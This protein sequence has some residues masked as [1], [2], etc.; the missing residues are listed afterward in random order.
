MFWARLREKEEKEHQ[1]KTDKERRKKKLERLKVTAD[2]VLEE[3]TNFAAFEAGADFELERRNLQQSMGVSSFLT[4]PD[5]SEDEEEESR[6]R[7][8]AR[9]LEPRPSMTVGTS[10]SHSQ[11]DDIQEEGD[12][13]PCARALDSIN[14]R[15]KGKQVS[16]MLALPL[17]PTTPSKAFYIDPANVVPVMYS[18]G[19]ENIG[20]AFYNFQLYGI[21]LAN[22]LSVRST[23]ENFACFLAI[24]YIWDTSTTLELPRKTTD[25]LIAN[26]RRPRINFS[27]L[28]ILLYSLETELS[29]GKIEQV[30]PQD[31]ELAVDIVDIFRAMKNDLPRTYHAF[32]ADDGEDTFVHK[33]LHAI[34]STVFTDFHMAWA[35]K[36]AKGSKARRTEGDRQGLRPD[37][38][39]SVANQT[40]LFLEVKPPTGTNESVYLADKWKLANLA[41]DELDARHKMEIRT[42]SL[43]GG[44]YHFHEQWQVYVP[45]ARD[46]AGP[47]RGCLEA[48]YSVKNWLKALHLP[49]SYELASSRPRPSILD[50]GKYPDSLGRRAV[51]LLIAIGWFSSPGYR[52]R[53]ILSSN[54]SFEQAWWCPDISCKASAINDIL[55]YLIGFLTLVEFTQAS[56][57]DRARPSQKP[58]TAIFAAPASANP[59]T[60][61]IPLDPHNSYQPQPQQPLAGQPYV[62]NPNQ[63]QP[64]PGYAYPSTAGAA[65]QPPA[66]QQPAAHTTPY[67]Y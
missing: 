9:G 63:P 31:D 55:G 34:F 26:L 37:L 60:Q 16:R 58:V 57:Y 33:T 1:E 12:I 56:R 61:Y 43:Q 8:K 28:V 44:I 39:I 35:N 66:Y 6:I 51:M 65:Y 46:D 18:L 42:V 40:V 52:L 49:P 22:N 29:N 41:K 5:I 30:A 10:S 62:Y 25:L 15:R 13:S 11:I 4:S 23:S 67:Q 3:A 24:N 32:D 50:D 47:I 21:S 27:K 14:E 54:L 17:K 45:R 2:T 36:S 7:K 20:R 19:G 53:L 48:L 38:Q 64:Q 59:N